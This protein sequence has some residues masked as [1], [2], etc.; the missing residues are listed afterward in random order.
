MYYEYQIT[1]YLGTIDEVWDQY[2]REI[3]EYMKIHLFQ[4]KETE[5]R[6]SVSFY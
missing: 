3:E 6:L 2:F 4:H 5:F 1:Y